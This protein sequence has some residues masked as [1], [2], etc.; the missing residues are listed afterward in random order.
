[1]YNI[2]VGGKRNPGVNN[3]ALPATFYFRAEKNV[4]R[5]QAEDREVYED[6]L[7]VRIGDPLDKFTQVDRKACEEDRQRYPLEYDF[8]S[9][10]MK[11]A[12]EGVSIDVLFPRSSSESIALRAQNV[13]CGRAISRHFNSR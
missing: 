11:A 5:S 3:A 4:A 1:V 9:S 2:S 6:I 8:F 10:K 13:F 7:W 12:K